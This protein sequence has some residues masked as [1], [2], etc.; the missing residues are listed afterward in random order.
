M[1]VKDIKDAIEPMVQ[2]LKNEAAQ[3]EQK[4]A[5]AVAQINEEMKKQGNSAAEIKSRITESLRKVR[6][7][8]SFLPKLTRVS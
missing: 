8:R 2:A 1:E 5:E 3:N 4:H 6:I 7:S